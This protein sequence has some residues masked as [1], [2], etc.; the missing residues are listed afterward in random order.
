MERLKGKQSS[1]LSFCRFFR[2]SLLSVTML[3]IWGGQHS[4][5]CAF[6]KGNCWDARTI[7]ILLEFGLQIYQYLS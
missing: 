6:R 7:E 2:G 3:L 5:T 4:V 1:V